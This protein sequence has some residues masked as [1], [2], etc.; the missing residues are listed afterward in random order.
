[1]HRTDIRAV[2]QT[3]IHLTHKQLNLKLLNSSKKPKADSTAKVKANP[4]NNNKRNRQKNQ[5]SGAIG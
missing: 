5:Q 4:T 3:T 2:R 1:V